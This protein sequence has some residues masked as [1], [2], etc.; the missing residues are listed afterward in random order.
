MDSGSFSERTGRDIFLLTAKRTV[1]SSKIPAAAAIKELEFLVEDKEDKI[2]ILSAT[3]TP[4]R[5]GGLK[6]V[7]LVVTYTCPGS[8]E[9][10]ELA[11]IFALNPGKGVVYEMRLDS[12]QS[13]YGTLPSVT[14]CD[15]QVLEIHGILRRCSRVNSSSPYHPYRKQGNC[16]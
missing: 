16:G 4:A 6:A 10:Y 14:G 12:T 3:I 13:Q 5:L 8:A 7:Q 15:D 1:L 2:E 9:R 11:S